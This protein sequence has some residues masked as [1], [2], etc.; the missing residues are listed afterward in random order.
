MFIVQIDAWMDELFELVI[1][2]S[3]IFSFQ[4]EERDEKCKPFRKDVSARHYQYHIT[5]WKVC[6]LA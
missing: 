2:F 4:S 6:C 3:A 5:L 1:W